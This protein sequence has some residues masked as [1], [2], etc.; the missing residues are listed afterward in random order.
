MNVLFLTLGYPKVGEHNI[1][2]DLMNEFVINE[3]KVYIACSNQKS[4]GQPTD[5]KD[6]DGKQVLRIRTGNLVGNASL[7]QKG[8]AMI[9]LE[10]TF[11]K[12]I[13]TY[14]YGIK[15]DLIIYST[16][17]IT[18]GKAV[19]YFKKRDN[20]KTYLL[21]KDIFPQNAVDIGMIKNKGLIYKFFRLKEKKLYTISDYIG[22]M[23]QANVDFVLRHNHNLNPKIVEICP[24]S[25]LP[26]DVYKTN[27]Q[28]IKEKYNIPDKSTIFIY[29]GNLGK[30]QG[31]DFVL[32]CLESN[33]NLND[34]FFIICGTGTEY[35]KL[36]A[37]YKEKSPN[38]ILLINGLAKDEYE[39]LLN[40]CD[41]GLIFLDHRF[42]IPNFPSRLLSYMEYAMPVVA[43]TD[44]SSDIGKIIYDG[45]FGWWCES[46]DAR[47]FKNIIDSICLSRDRLSVF[48]NYSRK[49]LEKNFTVKNSYEII[50]KHF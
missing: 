28:A 27:K 4:S 14:F 8:L 31:I 13:R 32:E 46:N 33:M 12:A 26:L 39:L 36:E 40:S 19:E 3:H 43:C 37:F 45:R 23:S 47:A 48:G 21:L 42:T 34:R 9:S 11:I 17:P 30:P 29:G 44:V 5:V 15:F 50:M 25:I 18:F 20:A 35:N 24:N 6:E 2:S 16:P 41:V 22:C 7:I 49:Y 38:N 1:Y 10:D